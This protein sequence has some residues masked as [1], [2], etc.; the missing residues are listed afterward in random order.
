M[1]FPCSQHKCLDP[2]NNNLSN[3]SNR[4]YKEIT[5]TDF[6]N[7][8]VSGY[9][10]GKLTQNT[11]DGTTDS[12]WIVEVQAFDNNPNYVYQSAT[13]A[14]N[15][16]IFTRY[17]NGSAWSNWE[18][19]ALK[20]DLAS[21]DITPAPISGLA[22]APATMFKKAGVAYLNLQISNNTSAAI[23]MENGKVIATGFPIPY[24][25]QQVYVEALPWNNGLQDQTPVQLH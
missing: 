19:L 10:F 12:N 2:Q 1:L 24:K 5:E 20:S 6:N 22:F 21:V 16:L 11:P 17:R 3:I 23:S 14:S 18:V 15:R 13:R 4:F 9:Y 8:R 7:L 25:K